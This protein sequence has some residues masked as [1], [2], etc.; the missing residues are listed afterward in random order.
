VLRNEY[1]NGLLTKQTL[2]DGSVY[3]Y[4]YD[5]TNAETIHH[6]TV[7]AP[8]GKTYSLEIGENSSIVHETANQGDA[9][10]NPAGQH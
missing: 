4:A 5:S 10:N 1:E 3:T 2:A 8:D 6:A 7:E 9:R